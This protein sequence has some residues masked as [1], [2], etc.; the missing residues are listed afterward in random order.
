MSGELLSLI[1]LTLAKLVTYVGVVTLTGVC[2]ARLLVVPKSARRLN[3]ADQTPDVLYARL[4]TGVVIATAVTVIAVVA[5]LHAQTYSSFGLDETVTL[6]LL[7]LMAF[8]SGWGGRWVLQLWAVGFVI[9]AVSLAGLQGRKG[10]WVIAVSVG[11]LGVTLPMT[12]HAMAYSDNVVIPL[13]LQSVH[14]LSAGLWIGT[15]AAIIFAAA[16][17]ATTPDAARGRWCAELVHTFSP[18]AVLAVGSIL[19]TGILTA[20]LYLEN[21]S[22]LWETTYGRTLLIKGALVLATGAVGTYNWLRP[23]LGEEKGTDT[24][25]YSA[26]LELTLATLLLMVTALLVHLPTPGH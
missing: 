14:V 5:R 26:G 6:K 4:W 1:Y 11:G 19:V 16:R 23:K 13:V 24:L 21:V 15:L 20:V 2:A 22:Q 18:L 8:E 7:N 12:G 3:R 9:L 17:L 10:W 25:F